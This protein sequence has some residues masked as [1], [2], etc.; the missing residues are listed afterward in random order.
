MGTIIKNKVLYTSGFMKQELQPEIYSNEEREVGVWTDGKP[1]YQKTYYLANGNNTIYTLDASFDADIKSN[2]GAWLDASGY[3]RPIPYQQSDGAVF[4]YSRNGVLYLQ[5]SP[6]NA[7]NISVTIQ[8][9]KTTDT[10]GS[11]TWTPSGVPAVHYDGNEKVIGTWFGETLYQK[12]FDLGDDISIYDTAWFETTISWQNLNA[13]RFVNADGCT[14]GGSYSG[15][16]LVSKKNNG[17]VEIQT[18]RNNNYTG[19]RYLTLTYTKTTD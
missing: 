14:S 15:T 9:T 13:N 18:P 2:A 17:F 10:A 6:S 19:V 8:Y 7:T 3:K 4:P 11:G 5:F 16:F 1:L 12:T